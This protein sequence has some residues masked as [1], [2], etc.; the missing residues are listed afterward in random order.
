[1][2]RYSTVSM[3]TLIVGFDSAWSAKNKGALAGVIKRPDQST[4]ELCG[5]TPQVCDFR[6]ATEL[7]Q[8]WTSEHEVTNILV[9]LDQPMV[10]NN[11]TG[12][13]P[14]E[15]LVSS[16]IGQRR[17]GV[18]PA[19]QS[20][21]QLFG[22]DAPVW[23]FLKQFPPALDPRSPQTGCAVIETYPVLS[24]IAWGW[25]RGVDPFSVGKLPKYNPGRK[26]S[27][28]LEDWR[29]VCDQVKM[30]FKARNFLSLATWVGEASRQV[31]PQKPD[32]D[33]LDACI[34]LL[35]G[36]QLWESG[37]C[38]LVGSLNSGYMVVPYGETLHFELTKRC[39]AK[40]LPLDQV[41]KFR[42]I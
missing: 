32:Q 20:R 16:S 24:M 37:E 38:M 21:R 23:N 30:G 35:V 34:C 25:L 14:V 7:L 1:M 8:Q 12:Q 2:K 3:S 5:G 13:R 33:R 27:F 26:K 29:F 18:Q 31:K 40:R 17:G 41:Q 28:N 11:P 4:I 9:M 6:K 36:L 19:N 42:W 15:N 39:E 22:S 10:V